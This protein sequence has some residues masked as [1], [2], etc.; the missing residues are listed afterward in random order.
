MKIRFKKKK[1]RR[2]LLFGVLFVLTGSSGILLDDEG[3]DWPDYGF[4]SIGVLYIAHYIHDIKLQYLILENG[5]IRK[6]RL[7]GSGIPIK[8]DD[9]IRIRKISGEYQLE[10]ERRMLTI[11]P[12]LIQK[13][14]LDKLNKTLTQLDLSADKTPFSEE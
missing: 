1:I 13:D 12:D 2:N 7:Y 14:S 9:I 10:T 5:S 6:N 11:D 8:L 4:M 3:A